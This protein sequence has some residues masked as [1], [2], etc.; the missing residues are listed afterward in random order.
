MCEQESQYYDCDGLG[1][2][3][4]NQSSQGNDGRTAG[5]GSGAH[6]HTTIRYDGGDVDFVTD[7]SDSDGELRD[8]EEVMR[9]E[10]HGG[11]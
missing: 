9:N 4:C 5:S 3:R 1:S 2:G 11:Y 10:D 6:G 7:S 8:V